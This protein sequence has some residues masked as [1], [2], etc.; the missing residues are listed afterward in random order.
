[1]TRDERIITVTK[2]LLRRKPSV[3]CDLGMRFVIW[4]LGLSLSRFYF[5][6]TLFLE[7]EQVIKKSTLLAY[8]R[9][10]GK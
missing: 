3:E 10:L 6:Q 1:M 8:F 5:L 2:E 4:S 7:Q 9:D